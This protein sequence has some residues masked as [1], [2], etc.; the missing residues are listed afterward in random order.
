LRT[1]QP[2]KMPTSG[3]SGPRWAPIP[4]LRFRLL[5][6]RAAVR[7]PSRVTPACTL[8]T[9]CVTWTTPVRACRSDQEVARHAQCLLTKSVCMLYEDVTTVRGDVMAHRLILTIEWGGGLPRLGAR[10]ERG[11]TPRVD[12]MTPP[13]RR[14]AR[15]NRRAAPGYRRAWRDRWGWAVRRPRPREDVREPDHPRA[16]WRDASQPGTIDPPT[17]AVWDPQGRDS[18]RT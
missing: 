2:P 11:P 7:R 13:V 8:E 10:L 5:P 12:C 9:P 17:E 18:G 6:G 1:R 14:F 16:R 3:R 4:R 15:G